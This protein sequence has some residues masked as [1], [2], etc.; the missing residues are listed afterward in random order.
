MARCY[1]VNFS[2]PF[3][4]RRIKTFLPEVLAERTRKPCVR[5]RLRFFGCQFRFVD[6]P[7]T[8]LIFP[9]NTTRKTQTMR[10]REPRSRAELTIGRASLTTNYTQA[11]FRVLANL[12]QRIGERPEHTVV[13]MRDQSDA[14]ITFDNTRNSAPNHSPNLIHTLCTRLRK[15]G[16]LPL[17]TNPRIM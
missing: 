2:R 13:V 16:A 6:M 5:A 8:I 11:P 14:N 4:R 17:G 9:S 10:H 3:R 1:T 7:T 15:G 12:A